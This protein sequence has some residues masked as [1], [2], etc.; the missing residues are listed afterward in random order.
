MGPLERISPERVK[1][2]AIFMGDGGRCTSDGHR[3]LSIP[4]RR[5]VSGNTA[6]GDGVAF[7]HAR[8]AHIDEPI[9]VLIRTRAP[10]A[11]GAS[12]RQPVATLLVILVP[13]QATD[14]HLS[15]LAAA[16]EFFSDPSLRRRVA[17]ATEP[18]LIAQLFFGDA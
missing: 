3:P 12:D 9:L 14:Q 4:R 7:P 16:A 6:V 8:V 17:A 11:F 15:I 5:D 2:Y 18:A 13:E 1:T 10:I